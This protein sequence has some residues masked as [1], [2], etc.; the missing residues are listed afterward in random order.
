MLI[1]LLLF[2]DE[3]DAFKRINKNAFKP[4]VSEAIKEMVRKNFTREI[5][6]YQFC[7]QRLHRQ[8]RALKLP[9]N[10]DSENNL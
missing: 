8:F 1:I 3:M 9:T 4:P 5:E 2:T 6:F 7:R 10:L